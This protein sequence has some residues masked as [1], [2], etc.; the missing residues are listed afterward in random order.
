[1]TGTIRFGAR[2]LFERRVADKCGVDHGQDGDDNRVA[3]E[4]PRV[5]KHSPVAFVRHLSADVR[6]GGG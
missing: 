4:S 5:I 2:S 6:I 3:S 1:V